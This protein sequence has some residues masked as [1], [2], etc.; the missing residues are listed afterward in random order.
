R[1]SGGGLWAEALDSDTD[2]L[3]SDS[4]DGRSHALNDDLDFTEEADFERLLETRAIDLE[5]GNI[6]RRRIAYKR[7]EN[8]LVTLTFPTDPVGLPYGQY[9]EQPKQIGGCLYLLGQSRLAEIDI[10]N[11][12]ATDPKRWATSHAIRTLERFLENFP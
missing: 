2:S 9:L 3:C 10:K 8:E 11:F 5:G 7:L 6:I 1:T 12:D 4:A